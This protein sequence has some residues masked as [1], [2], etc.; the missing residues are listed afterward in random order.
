LSFNK[1]EVDP[2][3]YYDVSCDD[4]LLVIYVGE[5]F[6]TRAERLIDGCKH[7]IFLDFEMKDFELMH[8]LLG[9]EVW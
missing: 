4:P 8:Y 5:I 6:I 9:F 1:S 7:S 3:L 2:N